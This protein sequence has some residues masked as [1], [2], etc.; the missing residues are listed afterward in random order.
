ME[1]FF[2]IFWLLFAFE[3][4]YL[5]F[6]LNTK[7]E[8]LFN[9]VNKFFI[10]LFFLI[11]FGLFHFLLF[12]YH[13]TVI[14]SYGFFLQFKNLLRFLWV[15]RSYFLF[16]HRW[17]YFIWSRLYIYWECFQVAVVTGSDTIDLS[18][19]WIFY[20]S[21]GSDVCHNSRGAECSFE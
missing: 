19:Q 3:L 18:H 10:V 1:L 8:S 21:P 17:I 20:R 9:Y 12:Y 2:I 16:Y 11:L 7:T 5:E 6:Y 14:T 15:V 13:S 4:L